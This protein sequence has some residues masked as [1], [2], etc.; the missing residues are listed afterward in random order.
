MER[1][2][3][4]K[5]SSSFYPSLRL[6]T[7]LRRLRKQLKMQP[8]SVIVEEITADS[9]K[10]QEQQIKDV[11]RQWVNSHQPRVQVEK[12]SAKEVQTGKE[13]LKY[14]ELML[15]ME[16]KMPSFPTR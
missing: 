14:Q 3:S 6:T 12:E 16:A 15:K 11:C 13:P 2:T 4:W 10:L 5:I 8:W 7:R 1:R 9:T